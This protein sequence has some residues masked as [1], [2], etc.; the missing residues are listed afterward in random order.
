MRGAWIKAFLLCTSAGL[1]TAACDGGDSSTTGTAGKGGTGGSGGTT[2]G[3]GGTA[4]TSG[5]GGLIGTGGTTGCGAPGTPCGPDG[6]GVCAGGVCC[7]AALACANACCGEGQVCSFQLC[8]TPGDICVDATDCPE[9]YL[10]DYSLGDGAGTGGSGGTGGAGGGT[11]GAG[12]MCQGGVV[13]PKGK[14][15]P[16]PEECAPGQNP[17]D[18]ITCLEKC[19][20]K[21]PSIN[22]D[23]EVKYAWGGDVI[24]PSTTDVM[25]TPIVVQLDDDNCDGK[26][27]QDDIPEIVFSTF[28]GGAYYK[29]GTLHAISIIDGAVVDKWTVPDSTQPG[30]GLAAADLDGD[31][32]PE[33]V[34]CM[35][36][37]PSGTKCCDDIAQNTGVIAFRAD[38]STFWTQT[39][40]TK[41]HCGYQHP[42]IGDVDQDGKPEVLIGH[43]LL[44]GATGMIEKELDPATSWGQT[45]SGLVDV[46]GDGFLDVIDGWRAYRADGSVIWDLR[47]NA[48]DPNKPTITN[49]YHAAGDFDGDGVA[50]VVVISSGAPHAMYVIG[51][52][53]ASAYGAKIIRNKIDINN[54]ISTAAFC[55]A[56]SEYGGGPPTVADFNGDGVPDIGAAGAVGYVV[57]DGK[58]LIDPSVPD[59]EITL[60]FKTT[61][62]CSSAVTGSAVFDFNGDGKAEAVYSDEYRL[63]MYDGVT[64]ENLLAPICNTTG[65]LWEYPVVAD[66]DNDGQA[67]IVVASNA[68]GITCP[69]DGSKQSGIRVFSS[70]DGSWVRTRRVWNQHTYHITNIGEDGSV[71]MIEPANWAQPGL[72]N[73]RQN[74]QPEGEFSA[75]DAVVS[76][77]PKCFGDFGLVATVRNL[78]SASLPAGVPVGFYYGASP[79]T[80][81]GEGVTK[82]TLYPAEAEAITLLLPNPPASI[83]Q[84]VDSVFA[85]VDDGAMMHSWHECRTDNNVSEAVSA[86][87]TEPQ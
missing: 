29:M 8:V 36:P 55:N 78:G 30:A 31:G 57:F 22:F 59:N 70:K 50:E 40:T 77:A 46:D 86:V 81:L 35:N 71:P 76:V 18:P 53:P 11:G 83:M 54:G 43:T 4:T 39:D 37:G 27:N 85:V 12:A 49:G 41:V 20:Y 23:A 73:Y 84:G 87:C 34:G 15:M 2:G 72:N 17:G 13:P 25:M 66:V 75:P 7:D 16:K 3:T 62:D 14:C 60:W 1:L 51:Y 52:D 33:I 10:C 38:G 74:R 21:P 64:G 56:G 61:H 5:T 9:D 79:G 63:Y 45:L 44:D 82:K 24:L 65:T 68:Y 6:K 48:M 80:K 58:K 28:S 26:V 42:A 47:P 32:V 19:E 67:D 69:D